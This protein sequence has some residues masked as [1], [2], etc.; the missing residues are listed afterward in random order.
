MMGQTGIC[1]LQM[2]ERV[3]TMAFNQ[4][5]KTIRNSLKDC[6][7]EAQL[8][9]LGLDPT[10]RAETLSLDDFATIANWVSEHDSTEDRT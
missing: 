5:R 4:R 6:I 10:R 8:E 3:C 1:E 2:L 9:A 7:D